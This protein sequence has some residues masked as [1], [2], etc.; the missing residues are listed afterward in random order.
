LKG[1]ECP[2]C[3]KQVFRLWEFFIFPSPFWINRTCMHCRKKV[4]FDMNVVMS[5]FFYMIAAIIIGI[6]I[7]K[8]I[9]FD[10]ILFD[11]VWYV[12]FISIP[13]IMGK[14]IFKT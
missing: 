14:K 10:S 6:A 7:D 5:I 9:S 8:I 11:I 3:N 4:R 1:F 13:F 2:H 12:F